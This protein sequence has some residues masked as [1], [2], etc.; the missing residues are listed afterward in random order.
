[1]IS[2]LTI[3]RE[4]NFIE[5]KRALACFHRQTIPEK[6][7][8]IVHDGSA[9]FDEVLVDQIEQY[10]HDTI[11]LH[12]SKDPGLPLGALRNIALSLAKGELICQWDDDD[13]YHPQRL[14][15]QHQELLDAGADFCFLTDQLHYFE[16]TG[17]MFWDDWTVEAYPG[18]LIQGSILGR[19]DKIGTYAELPRGEDTQVVARLYATG[20]RLR[21]IANR[22]YLYIYVFNGK[23]AWDVRHHAAISAWK[24]LGKAELLRRED[25]LRRQ[26]D[27]Y[28]LPWKK[29]FMPYEG[30]ALH[31]R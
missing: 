27:R 25:E 16:P 14:E 31:I 7:L 6:E 11:V 29:I 28:D 10:P 8:V 1:M 21:A 17:E 2:C 13:L 3:T 18:N 26:L 5:L 24:R 23:N 9:Q 22:G 30:G 15:L 20:C 12:R 19:A 4:Q